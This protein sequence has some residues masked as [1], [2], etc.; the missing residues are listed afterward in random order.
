MSCCCWSKKG[1]NQAHSPI[2]RFFSSISDSISPKRR[3]YITAASYPKNCL[4]C[5]SIYY[6]SKLLL[7]CSGECKFSHTP[8]YGSCYS[9]RCNS[10]DSTKSEGYYSD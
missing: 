5:N 7:Y 4:N 9:S 1:L 8:Q 10:L 3:H 6:N 2:K